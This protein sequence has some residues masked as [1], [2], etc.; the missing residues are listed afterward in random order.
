[1]KKLLVYFPVPVED[2]VFLIHVS[3]DPGSGL[4]Q[5]MD[6]EMGG[7]IIASNMTQEQINREGL[8]EIVPRRLKRKGVRPGNTTKELHARRKISKTGVEQEQIS[9]WTKVRQILTEQDK[10][11][12]ISKVVEIRV[13]MVMEN[14][15]Y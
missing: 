11:K 4:K 12:I 13:R 6:Y 7:K 3:I 1:M 15:M 2:E 9:K 8:H 14:H 10:R 5:N